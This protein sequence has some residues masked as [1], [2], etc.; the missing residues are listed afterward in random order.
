MKIFL[1]RVILI[2]F[3]KNVKVK[4]KVKFTLEQATK[5]KRVSRGITPL[6]L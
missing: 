1:I 4:I 6:F 5:A 2:L 3:T